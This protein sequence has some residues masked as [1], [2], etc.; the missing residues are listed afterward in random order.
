MIVVQIYVDDIVFGA[1]NMSLCKEFESI[2][3]KEFEM[4][5]MCELTF[6]LGLQIKQCKEG[7]FINQIKYTKELLKKFKMLEAKATSTPMSPT[8][9]MDL[10]EKGKSVDQKIYRGMIG[11]LLYLIANRPDP[12]Q[13][14]FVC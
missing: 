6:F 1:T 13:C 14:V 11:Y 12:F 9:K 10:D 8:T 3:Q 5:M 2:M 4:S 7:I